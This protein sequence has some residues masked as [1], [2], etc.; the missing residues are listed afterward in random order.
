MMPSPFPVG[1]LLTEI[2]IFIIFSA[3]SR[4]KMVACD[5]WHCM[6]T[7]IFCSSYLQSAEAHFSI[8]VKSIAPLH[9]LSFLQ[10]HMKG[11]K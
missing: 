4:A 3:L 2:N 9:N 5:P 8:L 6:I 11:S 1:D 7:Q 10:L